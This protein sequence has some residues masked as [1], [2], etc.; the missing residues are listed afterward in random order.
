MSIVDRRKHRVDIAMDARLLHK[1]ILRRVESDMP[2]ICIYILCH[3]AERLE[4]AE[5]IYKIYPWAVPILMKYQDCTFENAFWKQLLEIKDEWSSCE[6]VGTL[7]YKAFK[8]TDILRVDKIIRDR[9]RWSSGYFNFNESSKPFTNDHPN[10]I[11]IMKDVIKSMDLPVPSAAFYNYWMCTPNKMVR[12]IDWFE[13]KLKPT[14]LAH[15]LAM[16]NAMYSVGQ[17]TSE[18]CRAKFGVPFYPHVPFVLERL[19]KAFFVSDVVNDVAS[20]VVN[21]VASNLVN[22]VAS[23]V[24]NDVV[25]N[26]LPTVRIYILCYNEERLASASSIYGK[27]YWA[28]P[29]LMKYQDCTFEN[30]FWKQLLEIRSEWNECDMVGTLSYSASKKINLDNVDA[31]IRNKD[32]WN[33][34]YYNFA[35]STCAIREDGHPNLLRIVDDVCSTLNMAQ[36][37]LA[38]YNYWMCS[39]IRMIQFISWVTRKLIPTVLEHP[40]AMSNADYKEPS[41]SP[42]ECVKKFGVPHYP[43]VP[44]VLER[45]TKAFFSN[46][47]LNRTI[48]SNPR[49]I[50]FSVNLGGYDSRSKKH[51]AQT[52]P[53]DEVFYTSKE[54]LDISDAR[55]YFEASKKWRFSAHKL[56]KV[57]NYDIAIY[58]DSNVYMMNATFIQ[59]VVDHLSQNKWDMLMSPHEA[60]TTNV[61]EANECI[62]C[63][64]RFSD[65]S[66]DKYKDNIPSYNR[67]C[68]CGFNARWLSSPNSSNCAQLMD[69]WW[70][71][72][73]DDPYGVV[74]DQIEWPVALEYSDIHFPIVFS[75][76]WQKEYL[77][78][79]NFNI[80]LDFRNHYLS[81]KAK[82]P[83]IDDKLVDTVI[84]FIVCYTDREYSEAQYKFRSFFWAQP[85]RVDTL[86]NSY[87]KQ[88]QTVWAS[89]KYVGFAEYQHFGSV[90]LEKIHHYV[91]NNLT[92]ED[93]QYYYDA[94]NNN[95]STLLYNIWKSLNEDC[96]YNPF[97][98]CSS[99]RMNMVLH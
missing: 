63:K 10:L 11:T 74:N 99:S 94:D 42:E 70:E 33:Y 35:D 98:I 84:I 76:A 30:A 7:S 92:C 32:A 69:K 28:V 90:I 65:V 97:W 95:T 82:L 45:L 60:R 50:V 43:H 53:Y 9:T 4:A 1:R 85:I 61:E 23:N 79:K 54:D 5:E 62:K 40:L 20:N 75:H 44:F 46:L 52:Y 59:D 78:F 51:I 31:I 27:Y 87:I 39:P 18:Q 48:P 37:T 73:K 13:T 14:V 15:P 89:S 24:V 47:L 19:N 49:V 80:V 22:D 72:I 25:S 55:N 86:D 16:T 6:M 17:L 41:I 26:K 29:I 3:T 8:K 91:L 64:T 68:W 34:G 56:N 83:L 58:L 2:D 88:Q 81:R 36:P 71:M 67:L 21:D 57:K 93:I 77:L 96:A 38:Y 66:L 12:F